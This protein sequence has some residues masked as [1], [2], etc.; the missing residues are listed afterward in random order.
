MGSNVK[1]TSAFNYADT[2]SSDVFQGQKSKQ[3]DQGGVRPQNLLYERQHRCGHLSKY[4]EVDDSDSSIV[5]LEKRP[6]SLLLHSSMTSKHAQQEDVDVFDALRKRRH[7]DSDSELLPT[8]SNQ[9]SVVDQQ[10]PELNSGFHLYLTK[11]TKWQKKRRNYKPSRSM[12]LII[13]RCQMRLAKTNPELETQP[14]LPLTEVP[15]CSYQPD[16]DSSRIDP[17]ASPVHISAIISAYT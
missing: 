8:C 10:V 9:P 14:M 3:S 16:S 12:G 1:L 11:P 17:S 2:L 7:D 4:K 5:S 15:Q 6:A 13:S